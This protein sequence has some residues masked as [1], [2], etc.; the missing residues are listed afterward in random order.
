MYYIWDP[1][2]TNYAPLNGRIHYERAS[3]A[4]PT[5]GSP[6]YIRECVSIS[7]RI[8]CISKVVTFMWA[9]WIDVIHTILAN[10]IDSQEQIRRRGILQPISL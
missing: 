6:T 5:C 8:S 4:T 1:A 9:R 3:L 7:G 2:P 10:M